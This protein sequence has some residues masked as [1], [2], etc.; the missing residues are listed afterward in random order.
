MTKLTSTILLSAA[1][2]FTA[3]AHAA[4]TLPTDNLACFDFSD[5]PCPDGA[6]GV[7]Q[8]PVVG[9]IAGVRFFTTAPLA[10]V[11]DDGLTG[12]TFITRSAGLMPLPAGTLLPVSFKMDILTTGS[13]EV[14][15]W[16]LSFLYGSLHGDFNGAGVV[17]LEGSGSGTGLTGSGVLEFL[18][19]PDFTGEPP[20]AADLTFSSVQLF[21]SFT[22]EGTIAINAPNSFLL[23]DPGAVN[24]VPE[25][26]SFALAAAGIAGLVLVRARRRG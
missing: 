4:F 8:L 9:G 2:L 19:D 5:E 1:F 21:L 18:V 10:L 17:S 12:V 24:P 11:L 16:T 13:I 20:V 7:Q 14:G 26:A 6:I 25:P 23:G 22:G 3:P 15:E